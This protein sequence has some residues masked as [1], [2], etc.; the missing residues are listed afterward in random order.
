MQTPCEHKWH[1]V[2]NDIVGEHEC[3]VEVVEMIGVEAVAW[4]A[5]VPDSGQGDAWE[6]CGEDV[7]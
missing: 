2:Q 1:G 7:G 5:R 3:A 6:E 4:Y